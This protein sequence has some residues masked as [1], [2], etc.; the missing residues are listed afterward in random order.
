[1]PRAMESQGR[2]MMERQMKMEVQVE[3][4][5][6][7]RQSRGFVEVEFRIFTEGVEITRSVD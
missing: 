3:A 7:A 5:P 4:G 1:M 2:T 6:R